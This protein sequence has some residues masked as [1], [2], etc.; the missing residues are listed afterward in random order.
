MSPR[1]IVQYGPD[2]TRVKSTM[3]RPASG[4]LSDTPPWYPQGLAALSDVEGS[5]LPRVF[6]VRINMRLIRMAT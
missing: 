6:R 3:V 2:S 4:P 1:S 5:N